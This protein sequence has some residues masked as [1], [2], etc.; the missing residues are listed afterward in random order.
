M[1][2]E[3]PALL[4]KVMTCLRAVLPDPSVPLEPDTEILA[5]DGVDSIVIV[6]LLSRLEEELGVEIRPELISPEGFGTP[7]RLAGTALASGADP[8]GGGEILLGVPLGELAAML[9][10][11]SANLESLLRFR[12]A[13]EIPTL[14][15]SQLYA[16]VSP[17]ERRVRFEHS[18]PAGVIEEWAGL[19]WAIDRPAD[20]AALLESAERL[21]RKGFPVLVHADA[22]TV[23]WNPYYGREH[24]EHAFVLDGFGGGRAHVVDGY[25]NTT[26]H[27]AAVPFRE[28][29]PVAELA[30]LAPPPGEPGFPLLHLEERGAPR[31]LTLEGARGLAAGNRAAYGRAIGEGRGLGS[32]V[33]WLA[34]GVGEEDLGWLSLLSW[35]G[36][37]SRALHLQWWREIEPRFP[38]EGAGEIAD[39][40]AEVV[41]AWQGLQSMAFIAHQRSRA[42]RPWPQ[43]LGGALEKVAAA[44]SGWLDRMAAWLDKA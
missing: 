4:E 11:V 13:G 37:R 41:A 15:G 39:F 42:G 18:P 1:A 40:G 9:P 5:L 27:G 22:G 34:G 33:S 23:P 21:V 30:S 17:A 25:V 38:G 32:L 36:T 3:S 10:C 28:W 20:P 16:E 29:K 7:R 26:P 35:L 8:G 43:A 6:A 24:F 2:D 19:G 12:G 14:L 31:P 44:E